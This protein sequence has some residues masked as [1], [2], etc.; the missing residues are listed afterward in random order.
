MMRFNYYLLL[1][2]QYFLYSLISIHF[3]KSYR[4]HS[5]FETEIVCSFRFKYLLSS[6]CKLP[7]TCSIHSEYTM[8]LNVHSAVINKSEQ[9]NSKTYRLKSNTWIYNVVWLVSIRETTKP[10]FI[11]LTEAGAILSYLHNS[12]NCTLSSKACFFFF[13][14]IIPRQCYFSARY[15]HAIILFK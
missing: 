2:E 4:R 13:F 12:Y 7:L 5:H 8:P 6:E 9:W 10:P 3:H 14:I 11:D 1:Y 15:T